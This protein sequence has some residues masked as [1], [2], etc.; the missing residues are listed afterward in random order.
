MLERAKSGKK[1]L[2]EFTN[3]NLPP[4]PSGGAGL[5]VA[6]SMSPTSE[7]GEEAQAGTSTTTEGS[8]GVHDEKYYRNAMR[9]LRTR[10]EMH[11]RQL[12]VL[13]QKLSQNQMQFY[14]DPQKTLEQEFSRADVNKFTRQIEEK[15]Q[16]IAADETAIE[17]LRDQLRREGG[18]S[19][20]LR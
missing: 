15:K 8:P 9:E 4:R 14:A 6:A 16:E 17:D 10:Q 11:Q 18:P 12:A 3:D 20:W 1:P 2:K 19:G 7:T 13:E 5:T